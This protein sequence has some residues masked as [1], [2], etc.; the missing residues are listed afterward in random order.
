MANTG[1]Q[2]AG[3]QRSDITGGSLSTSQPLAS[4]AVT[5][6]DQRTESANEK[7]EPLKSANEG[8][9][10]A[11]SIP[12]LYD[13]A[14]AESGATSNLM[15]S[16]DLISPDDLVVE[17]QR[18]QT[19][20][21]VLFSRVCE[22]ME[23]REVSVE[24]LVFFLEG[25]SALERVSVLRPAPSVLGAEI[26]VL[27]K[28]TSLKEVF[29]VLR[30]YCSFFN[31]VLLSGIIEMFCSEDEAVEKAH[32]RLNLQLV[33]YF[34]QRVCNC[35]RKNM[36]GIKREKG[37]TIV[38]MKIDRQWASVRV[39]QLAYL[40]DSIAHALHLK[41]YTL[42]LC[43]AERGCFEVT[44]AVPSFVVESVFIVLSPEQKSGLRDLGV[45]S[46]S[47]E[48]EEGSLQSQVEPIFQQSQTPAK[49]IS[50]RLHGIGDCVDGPVS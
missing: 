4:G 39:G 15:I 8:V 22:L 9:E 33:H 32:V 5:F 25:Q 10:S 36:F 26:P 20:F 47:F 48:R 14:L 45:L 40:R 23:Q 49:E 44:F 12:S 43:A 34:R 3:G 24:R 18:I 13:Q 2:V 35:P 30:S 1:S 28:M 41:R 29:R 37:G 6:T 19:T 7:A 46:M 31:H 17:T 11:A 42:L 21:N 50:R 16:S 27:R 38:R